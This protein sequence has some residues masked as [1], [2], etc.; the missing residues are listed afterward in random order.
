MMVPF[1]MVLLQGGTSDASMSISR[2]HRSTVG[3]ALS[4]SALCR[5]CRPPRGSQMICIVWLMKQKAEF[6]QIVC[7][8][9]S[10]I[11]HT[12][13]STQLR[14]ISGSSTQVLKHGVLQHPASG[15]LVSYSHVHW[16]TP[17]RQRSSAPGD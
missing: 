8:L 6:V 10:T 17:S 14:L 1:L 16:R 5:W 9:G 7:H 13:K 11:T 2:P 15:A 4:E 12:V 3:H